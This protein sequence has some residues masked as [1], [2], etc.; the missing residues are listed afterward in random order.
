MK[1]RR[2]F[3]L[4]GHNT[5]TIADVRTALK[6]GCNAI[7]CDIQI[8]SNGELVINHG[9]PG[10]DGGVPLDPYLNDVRALLGEFPQLAMVMF[11]SKIKGAA[12]GKHLL[13]RIRALLTKDIFLPVIIS[14]AKLDMDSFFEDIRSGLG[15]AE[16]IM[17]D[18]E[19]DPVKIQDHFAGQ[20]V[21]NN[22]YGN[23]IF[24]T[25]VRHSV[26]SSIE[27]GA[28]LKAMTGKLK[29]V[30]AWTIG[31]QSTMREMINAG[32]D[33][34]II[35][36]VQA[37]VQ[38]VNEPAYAAELR[39]AQRS[40]NPFALTQPAYGLQINTGTRTGAGTDANIRFTLHGS[41]GSA[42][43]SIDADLIRRFEAGNVN[44]IAMLG[45]DL[46]TPLSVSVW[47]DNAGNAPDWFLDSITVQSRDF[48]GQSFPAHFD[49]WV[50]AYTTVTRT[51]GNTEY[52]LD[53]STADI[54]AGGTDANITCTLHGADGSVS[55]TVESEAPGLFEQKLS[56]QVHLR[57]MDI[58]AIKSLTL[59]IDD[60]GNGPG[61]FV[62]NASATRKGSGVV[63]SFAFHQ[64]VLPGIAVNR[65]AIE[66]TYQLTVH[67]GTLDNAGT[68]ANVS[69][70]LT[71]SKGSVSQALDAKPAGRLE[72]GQANTV[73]LKGMDV[74]SLTSLIISTDSQGNAPEWFVNEVAVAKAGMGANAVFSVN[75]WVR[76]GVPVV[77][78]P[79]AATYTLSVHTK[80]GAGAGTDANLS[81]ALQGTLGT[82][83]QTV[84]ANPPGKFEAG[85]TNAVTLKGMDI[86]T[87]TALTVSQDGNH[88]N[89]EWLL[90]TVSASKSGSSAVANFS[91]DQL[92]LENQPVKRTP[93]AATY[94]LVVKTDPRADAGTNAMLT[95]VLKGELGTLS[96]TVD[97]SPGGMFEAGLSNN[98]VLNGMDIGK[99]LTL[100]LSQDGAGGN[101][102]WYP[103]TVSA[104]KAGSAVTRVFTFD[105]WI[106]EKQPVTRAF[107]D[108]VYVL[109]VKTD[110][111]GDAGTDANISFTL[112]GEQGSVAKTVDAKPAGLFEAGLNNAVTLKG[113]NIGKLTKLTVSHDSDGNGPEWYLDTIGVTRNGT[114]GS[115]PFVFKQWIFSGAAVTKTPADASYVLTVH[116]TDEGGAGTDS[117]ITFTLHGSLGSVTQVVDSYPK[118]L[119][120]AGLSNT[121]TLQ[122][123]DIGTLDKITVS[124]DDDGNGSGWLLGWIAVRKGGVLLKKYTFN[125]W[126]WA[127]TSVSRT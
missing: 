26:R 15:D 58:G 66:A 123:S 112:Y 12:N 78:T 101:D 13:D 127:G 39:I 47:R 64:W 104:S 35:N 25:G 103:A 100:T 50:P 16:G 107:D 57:G 40:D 19:K 61:W 121:V 60:H 120:E 10:A 34:L 89:D 24:V 91:F 77:R 70:T 88:N 18:E 27:Q 87:I 33:G 80:S 118:G 51:F 84:D 45:N 20:G 6:A 99:I 81:F 56:N 74:G 28:A 114:P 116:T 46:G 95:F 14:V 22:C 42:T 119:F 17:I 82:V 52:V 2:P 86:G 54:G 110:P 113:A 8:R 93:F 32:A 90:D 117:N 111:R 105:Q 102:E 49:Q 79:D 85:L 29:W 126:I 72:A 9:D 106:K 109:Q 38:V 63:K 83:T 67:T 124:H 98:V 5:N 68:D 69:F 125:Q 59:Q 1:I 55:Q 71:G 65:A 122:G 4:I 97:A 31:A 75:Q 37:L 53:I 92:I 30:Y 62:G 108:A 115:T 7:E 21:A 23:G 11:D 41:K 73:L 44:F 43:H 76:P 36:D 48:P 3:Y 94:N 96:R